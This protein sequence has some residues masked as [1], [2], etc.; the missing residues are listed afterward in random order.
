[1]AMLPAMLAGCR[2]TTILAQPPTSMRSNTGGQAGFARPRYRDVR[3]V[4]SVR[5]GDELAALVRRTAR[6]R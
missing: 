1:M 5:I 4:L 6:Q 3:A 2:L